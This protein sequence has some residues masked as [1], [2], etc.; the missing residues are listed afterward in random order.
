MWARKNIIY[1]F[2]FSSCEML[3]HK[4][5]FTKYYYIKNVTKEC[6]DHVDEVIGTHTGKALFI[7]KGG[8]IIGTMARLY[9]K[10]WYASK[11]VGPSLGQVCFREGW[12]KYALGRDEPSVGMF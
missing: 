1:L 7:N 5:I 12:P 4:V 3:I 9:S 2:G 6:I 10:C 11:R 8:V